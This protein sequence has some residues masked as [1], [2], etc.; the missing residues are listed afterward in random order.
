MKMNYAFCHTTRNKYM[1]HPLFPH[2]WAQ[3]NTCKMGKVV[4]QEDTCTHRHTQLK[5]TK[6]V[7]KQRPECIDANLKQA[8]ARRSQTYCIVLGR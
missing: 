2:N 5:H 8:Q 7:G 6:S 3:R 4:V 1:I